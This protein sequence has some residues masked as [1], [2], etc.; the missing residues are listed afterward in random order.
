M[1]TREWTNGRWIT[2]QLADGTF[3]AQAWGAT[4]DGTPAIV[5]EGTGENEKAARADLYAKLSRWLK[6][7]DGQ[8]ITN[9]LG[10]L[11]PPG[12]ELELELREVG[13]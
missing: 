8:T 6:I 11:L 5:A 12:G 9:Q 10:W 1:K 4:F 13:G 3:Y 2:E 7:R